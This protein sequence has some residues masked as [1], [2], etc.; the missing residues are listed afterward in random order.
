MKKKVISLLLVA[1]LAVTS[2]GL[3]GCEKAKEESDSKLEQTEEIGKAEESEISGIKIAWLGSDLVYGAG[4]DGVSLADY[5]AQRNDQTI[6]K[7]AVKGSSLVESGDDGYIARL[8][9]MDTS[10]DYDA[11]IVEMPLCDVAAPVGEFSDSDNREEYDTSTIIGSM[12]YIQ[13]YVSE[14]FGIDVTFM[15]PAKSDIKGG[16][17]Y[18]EVL[19]KVVVPYETSGLQIDLWHNVDMTSA[20]ANYVD[21]NGN[22]TKEGYINMYVPFIETAL[23]KVVHEVNVAKINNLPEYDPA[24]VEA[25]DTYPNL[26][27]KKIIFLGSSVTYG[28]ASKQASFVEYMAARDGIEY[29]KEAVSGTTL[30]NEEGNDS[31]YIARMEAN[32]PPQDADLFVCQLSTNDATQDKPL[33]EISESMDMNDFDQTTVAG[34][35]EYVIAYAKANYN[36]PVM[37]YTGTK[38]DSEKYQEMVDLLLQIQKKWDIGVIDMWNDLPIEELE[39]G[40][41][42]YYM[43]N[44]VH[45]DRAGYLEWW[46][47]FMEKE[48]SEYIK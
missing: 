38:Y 19:W 45:P 34:A 3:M 36:C 44:G 20:D 27:G 47:P 2:L 28:S 35:I 33:G 30:V 11:F 13:S 43:A 24:N 12:Q 40:K 37:F 25:I 29:V 5:V 6:T 41:Y 7:E 39:A 1:T 23:K 42:D 26:K 9:K 22:P 10:V 46:T 17:A 18:S 8:K 14:N 16:S 48:I 4:N 21:G 32:I 15:T 31:S